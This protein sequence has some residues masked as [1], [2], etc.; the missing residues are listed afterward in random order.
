M[1]SKIYK[2]LAVGLTLALLSSLFA[3]SA[4]VSGRILGWSTEVIPGTADYVTVNGISVTD[5]AVAADGST[6]YAGTGGN[7]LYKSVN[8]GV[9][10]SQIAYNTATG[11]T[12]DLLAVA[13]DDNDIVAV[14]DTTT[15]VIW[16]TTNGGTT[17][18]TL[19]VPG[20]TTDPITTINEIDISAASSGIH[21]LAVAG[22]DSGA[23]AVW[24]YNIGAA[25][26]AWT[27]ISSLTG[28]TSSTQT[29]AAALAYSPN[30]PSDQVL[31]VVTASDNG[32][33]TDYVYLQLFSENSDQWNSTAGFSSYPATVTSD[34]A[35]SITGVTAAAI[36]LDPEFRQ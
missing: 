8:R 34:T 9:A 36:T 21:Y 7:N 16:I 27:K 14:A 24:K 31:A 13:P 12:S 2:V 25:A 4:P 5:I 23:P 33:S 18:G 35:A 19:G 1:K 30:F 32:T 26:P 15:E 20:G 17:W 11:N 3:F 22:V 29:S 28:F 10:W 6:V